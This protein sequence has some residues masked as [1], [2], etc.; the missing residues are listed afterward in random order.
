MC[1]DSN[2]H[3]G[4]RGFKECRFIRWMIW[5]GFLQ[6]LNATGKTTTTEIYCVS[7]QN[8]PFVSI[9]KMD[10]SR[11]FSWIFFVI[12]AAR[13]FWWIV[14]LDLEK[15]RSSPSFFSEVPF[16]LL[17]VMTA[18]R[19]QQTL[20][21]FYVLLFNTEFNY[22]NLFQCTLRIF[23]PSKL[24]ILRTLPLLSRFKPF[25]WRVQDP[26]RVP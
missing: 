11:S 6:F 19:I 17:V 2:T 14:P 5:L 15:H 22:Q 20:V 1:L 23:G 9:C 3:E 26:Y 16:F 10:G 21:M 12:G 7:Q 18:L 4:S 8:Q 13:V 25:H 24:A